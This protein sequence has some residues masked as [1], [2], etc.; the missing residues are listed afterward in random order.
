MS[1]ILKLI[2][3]QHLQI[4]LSPE[5]L[6]RYE[7]TAVVNPAASTIEGDYCMSILQ[8]AVENRKKG[9]PFP[10]NDF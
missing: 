1:N 9:Q 4:A 2:S 8:S 5:D 7:Q 10:K 3:S 6:K